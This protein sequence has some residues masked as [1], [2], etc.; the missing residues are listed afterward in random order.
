[1][2]LEKSAASAATAAVTLPPAV[3]QITPALATNT[4]QVCEVANSLSSVAVTIMEN[5]EYIQLYRNFFKARGREQT[6]GEINSPPQLSVLRHT[7]STASCFVDLALWGEFPQRNAKAM[8]TSGIAPGPSGYN[9]PVDFKGPP[10]ID[11]FERCWLNFI[12][13]MLCLCAAPCTYLDMHLA[14]MKAWAKL[15]GTRAWAFQYQCHCRFVAEHMPLTMMI[16]AQDLLDARVKSDPNYVPNAENGEFDP[17]SPW[18]YLW[19]MGTDPKSTSTAEWY[20]WENSFAKQ[21]AQISSGAVSIDF[22]LDGEF[23]VAHSARQHF[24]LAHDAKAILGKGAAHGGGDGAWGSGG[25]AEQQ[26]LWKEAQKQQKATLNAQK[27]GGKAANKGNGGNAPVVFFKNDKNKKLCPG[28]QTG[29]CRSTWLVK[30]SYNVVCPHD[31]ELRHQ[32]NLCLSGNHAP[33]SCDGGQPKRQKK[34]GKGATK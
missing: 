11:A 19:K 2:A 29:S 28:F 30:H 32:C 8:K 18:A 31:K 23:A 22:Y 33:S 4:V 24:A 27:G 3:V 1:V 34:G 25:K 21:A 7:L 26:K 13:A 20:F 17:A 16:A 10:D 5:P 9:L 6:P 14:R 15:Y 12:A